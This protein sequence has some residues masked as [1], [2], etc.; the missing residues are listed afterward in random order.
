MSSASPGTHATTRAGVRGTRTRHT[1][2]AARICSAPCP[3]T[4]RS[5]TYGPGRLGLLCAL[6]P[7]LPCSL[8]VVSVVYP[9]PY[10][11][12]GRFSDIRLL[13]DL[14]VCLHEG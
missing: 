3:S 8:I 2:V 14:Q 12:H 11:H 9:T 10:R 5:S 1:R 7:F 4:A 13:V 6:R